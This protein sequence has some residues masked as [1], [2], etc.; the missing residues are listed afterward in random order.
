MTIDRIRP[1]AAIAALVLILAA[2][3]GS[4][5]DT[6]NGTA[7]TLPTLNETTAADAEPDAATTTTEAVDPEEAMLEYAVC[8]R[9]HGVDMPDPGSS[10]DGS[11]VIGGSGGEG[12][13]EA[14][15]EAA[16]ECDPILESAFGDFE[17]TPEQETE[18][19]DQQ[20][21]FAQC[22]R[23]QGVDWPDPDPSGEDAVISI[24]LGDNG[25]PEAMN[26]AM[27]KCGDGLFGEGS[28]LGFGVGDTP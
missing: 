19:M 13:F 18:F 21:A 28:G 26:A 11:F 1:I 4:G 22:M 2:C 10:G 25:D 12:D 17:L 14:F 16:A 8:M 27:E 9:E 24:E 23:D 6:A 20:L 15:E 7:P 3:G 5:D